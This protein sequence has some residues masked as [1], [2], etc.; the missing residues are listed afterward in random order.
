MKSIGVYVSN[1]L[2]SRHFLKDEIVTVGNHTCDIPIPD[3]ERILFA[4]EMRADEEIGHIYMYD[5]TP[6]RVNK[7]ILCQS[8]I[9]IRIGDIIEI[10]TNVEIRL[11]MDECVPEVKSPT[12]GFEVP[13]APPIVL[14]PKDFGLKP[15]IPKE[16][17]ELVPTDTEEVTEATVEELPPLPTKSKQTSILDFFGK[18]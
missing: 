8:P 2:V 15:E 9:E 4:L 5:Q 18:K 14:V 12:D 17:E 7:R 13:K 11:F 16:E 10:D 3:E 1:E 6:I